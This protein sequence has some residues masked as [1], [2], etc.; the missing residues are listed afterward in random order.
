MPGPSAAVV[1]L[2]APFVVSLA[3]ATLPLAVAADG[4]LVVGDWTTGRIYRITR[5]SG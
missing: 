1:A 5:S 3:G 4:A 2:M